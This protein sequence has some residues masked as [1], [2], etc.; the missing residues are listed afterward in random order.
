VIDIHTHLLPGVDDGSPTLE[1][2]L[3]VLERMADEGVMAVVCTPHLNAS[4]AHAAPVKEHVGLL[5]ALQ[6]RARPELELYP[7]WEIMLDR[8][9]ADLTAPALALGG[10]SARLVEFPRRGLPLWATEELVR[11]R[12]SGIVPVVAHPERYG[13]C[14]LETLRGWHELGA[15]IQTDATAVITAGPMADFARAMLADGLVHVLASDNHGDRRSLSTVRRWLEEIDAGEQ[16][17]WL[18]HENPRRL[19]DDRAPAAVA[20][21][22]MRSGMV[23]RLKA[24]FGGRRRHDG[25]S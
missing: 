1:H 22:R 17:E 15:F 13:G 7:G 25:A 14:T 23:E 10:S 12:R 6:A 24:W 2:S 19:L 18:T 8:G 3:L 16:A 21:V 5:E 20:P 9:G 11:L 4:Q